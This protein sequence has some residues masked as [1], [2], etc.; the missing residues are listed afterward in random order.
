MRDNERQC[1][2]S[3]RSPGF[4]DLAGQLINE[5]TECNTLHEWL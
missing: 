2:A 4:D 5:V 1:S 3:A